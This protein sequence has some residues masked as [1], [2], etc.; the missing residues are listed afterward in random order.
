MSYI[1]LNNIQY[2]TNQ[3]SVFYTCTSSSFLMGMLLTLY[4]WRS[5]FE[6]GELIIFL[7]MC[8]GALKWRCLFFLLEEVTILLNFIVRPKQKIQ[9]E[10]YWH[11]NPPS[12][13]PSWTNKNYNSWIKSM[14][15][16]KYFIIKFITFRKFVLCV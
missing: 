11:T 8:E 6:R 13:H 5:S 2:N 10:V 15:I 3:C 12:L 16:R 1:I 4:F 7:R 9:R 14:W